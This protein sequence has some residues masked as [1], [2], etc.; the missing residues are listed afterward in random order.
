MISDKPTAAEASEIKALESTWPRNLIAEGLAEPLARLWV[1][2]RSR[3]LAEGHPA[4]AR[5]AMNDAIAEGLFHARRARRLVRGLEGAEASLE[6]QEVDLKKVEAARAGG[7]SVRVSRL[8]IVSR[9]GSSRFFRQVE[10][11]QARFANRLAVLVLECD[12]EALGA[13]AFG[14]GKQARAMLLDHKDAVIR[15]LGLLD[16]PAVDDVT[17][18]SE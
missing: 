8:L 11:I 5:H 10:K 18:T 13:A 9:D 16:L 1:Q 17:G 12:E 7:S 2:S 4:F 6:S 3:A 14:P 15:F